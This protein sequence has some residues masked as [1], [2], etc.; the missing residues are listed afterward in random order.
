MRA[1]KKK[2][3]IISKQILKI[4][5]IFRNTELRFENSAGKE[6]YLIF[7]TIEDFLFNLF[8]FAYKLEKFVLFCAGVS[9]NK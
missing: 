2:I 9:V 8:I 5:E 1:S 7:R 3:R 6:I 4:T